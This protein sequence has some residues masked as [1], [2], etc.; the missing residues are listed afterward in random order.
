MF[1]STSPSSA[2]GLSPTCVL[3]EVIVNLQEQNF[4]PSASSDP[5]FFPVNNFPSILSRGTKV[6]SQWQYL[7]YIS[8]LK[9]VRDVPRVLPRSYDVHHLFIW[10]KITKTNKHTP[11]CFKPSHWPN[12]S[13]EHIHGLKTA[14]QQLLQTQPVLSFPA[15]FSPPYSFIVLVLNNTYL[16][17]DVTSQCIRLSYHC[18]VS[19]TPEH[20]IPYTRALYPIHQTLL[21]SRG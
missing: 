7:Q 21:D 2:Y 11:Y 10:K 14:C 19:H 5:K 12:A 17:E 16:N 20:C 18:T 6:R 15:L 8:A 13:A 3:V 1:L 4:L 9:G